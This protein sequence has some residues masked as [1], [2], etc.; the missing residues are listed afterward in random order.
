M[1][2]ALIESFN[3]KPVNSTKNKKHK[4]CFG[5]KKHIFCFSFNKKELSKHLFFVVS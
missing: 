5:T 1:R 2:K 4:S 3:F